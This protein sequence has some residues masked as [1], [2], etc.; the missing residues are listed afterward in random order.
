MNEVKLTVNENWIWIKNDWR[1]SF[2]F[3]S[4]WIK[5]DQE[6]NELTAECIVKPGMN[7]INKARKIEAAN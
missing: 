6:K 5:P 7:G 3:S 2:W 4:V 1:Q